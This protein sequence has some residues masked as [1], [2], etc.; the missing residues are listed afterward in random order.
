MKTA[1]KVT[2]TEISTGHATTGIYTSKAKALARAQGLAG[3][4]G[5]E[6]Q[7]GADP[8]TCAMYTVTIE[9]VYIRN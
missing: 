8:A 9:K 4:P 6:N 1:Y 7:P 3:Y 5:S 2:Q